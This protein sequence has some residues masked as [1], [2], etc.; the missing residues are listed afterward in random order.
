MA[1]NYVEKHH[2]EYLA[3]KEQ[4][5]KAHKMRLRKYLEA[6]RK[7]LAAEKEGKTE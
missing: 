4:K 5:E 7:K 6:Y 2:L 3:K 1:D